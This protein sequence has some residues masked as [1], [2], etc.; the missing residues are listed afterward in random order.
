MRDGDVTPIVDADSVRRA[1]AGAQ[2]EVCGALRCV[3]ARVGAGA[4]TRRRFQDHVASQCP[5]RRDQRDMA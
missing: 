1:V 3:S 5:W 2:D 4:I